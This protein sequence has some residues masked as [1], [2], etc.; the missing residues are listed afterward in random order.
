MKT[1][2]GHGGFQVLAIKVVQLSLL[3][4]VEQY[5]VRDLE[6][7]RRQVVRRKQAEHIVSGEAVLAADL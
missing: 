6:V 1:I 7:Q 4:H 2:L 5:L 3:V